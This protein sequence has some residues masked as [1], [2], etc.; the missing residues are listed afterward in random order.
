MDVFSRTFLPASEE[1][2]LPIPKVSRHMPAIRRYVKPDEP[3]FFIN[4]CLRPERPLRGEHLLLLTQRRL[5]VTRE[6][7]FM[8]RIQLHL[9]AELGH[10]TN[11]DWTPDLRVCALELAVTTRSGIRERFWIKLG[12]KTRVWHLVALLSHAFP[13]RPATATKRPETGGELPEHF[14]EGWFPNRA[15]A[16]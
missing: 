7:R 2:K 10:L 6:T 5:V 15:T 9:H 8:H 11:V 4:R 16:A 1:A 13:P 3:T 14:D 12:T